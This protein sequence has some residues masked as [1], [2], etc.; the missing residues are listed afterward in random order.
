MD[1]STRVKLQ[2]A[3]EAIALARRMEEQLRGGDHSV[4]L[5][6]KVDIRSVP[7]KKI[8]IHVLGVKPGR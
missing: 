4:D 5:L 8:E 6:Q 1:D 2:R 7:S 3:D